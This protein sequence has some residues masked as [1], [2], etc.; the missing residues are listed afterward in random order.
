MSRSHRLS[1]P[2]KNLETIRSNVLIFLMGT[3]RLRVARGL[4]SDGHLG[5]VQSQNQHSGARSPKSAPVLL[6]LVLAAL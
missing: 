2:G 5:E 4:S 3:Q 1:G 6:P